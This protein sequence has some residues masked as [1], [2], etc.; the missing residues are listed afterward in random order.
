MGEERG[1]EARVATIGV[2]AA[3]EFVVVAAPLSVIP[4]DEFSFTKLPDHL[5]AIA[6]RNQMFQFHT[7]PLYGGR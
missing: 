3:D 4:A 2:R 7:P 6:L 5:L 1:P